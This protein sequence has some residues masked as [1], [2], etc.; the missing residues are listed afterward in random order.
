MQDIPTNIVMW[1]GLIGFFLPPIM[2]VIIQT[3]WSTR[4][5][6]IVAFMVAIAAGAGTA[7]FSGYLERQDFVTCILITL[8]VGMA[9]Y[10]G[11][12]KPTGIS[13]TI[14]RMTSF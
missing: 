9:T 12:W 1:S 2:S 3:G 10:Q 13:P 5:Q 4:L 8:T 11:F 7:Y 14:E 6:S